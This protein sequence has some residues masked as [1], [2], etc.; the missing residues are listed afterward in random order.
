MSLDNIKTKIFARINETFIVQLIFGIVMIVVPIIMMFGIY[1]FDLNML[2]NIVSGALLIVYAFRTYHIRNKVNEQLQDLG[3]D[4]QTFLHARVNETVIVQLIFGIA[5]IVVPIIM[6]VSVYGFDLN[7]LISTISGALL[8]YYAL[9]YYR[10]RMVKL[11]DQ[12]S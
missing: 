12:L 8:I 11:I 6:M 3:K 2:F 5:M 10:I 4:S 9:R 7:L 1:G